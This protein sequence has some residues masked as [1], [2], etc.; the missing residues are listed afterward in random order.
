MIPIADP[1]AALG[2]VLAKRFAPNV[3]L[4]HRAT[5]TE[6]SIA[7][8]EGQRAGMLPR[9]PA[10]MIRNVL[11]FTDRTAR[12]VMIPRR[13]ITAVD[14]STTLDEALRI[15]AFEGHSRYPVFKDTI[16]NVLGL[17]YAKDL[18]AVVRDPNSG[19][20]CVTD[21]LRAPV[22][23]VAESQSALSILREM[24]SLIHI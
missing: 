8:S 12:D 15:V 5:E 2:R 6:V 22:L 3:M 18:F 11:D 14:G 10:E 7:V 1:L 17:L 19:A 16:D 9:E 24:L 23:F 21:I 20:K 4:D 13:R